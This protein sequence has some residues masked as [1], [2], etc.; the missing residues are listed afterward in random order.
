[1]ACTPPSASEETPQ[2]STE[3]QRRAGLSDQGPQPEQSPAQ[4][5]AA[6]KTEETAPTPVEVSPV[7]RGV[8]SS[9]LR[10][11]SILEPKERASVRSL[12]SGVVSEL[13]VEEGDHVTSGELIAKISRPGAGSMLRQAAS[14]YYK[15]KRDAQRIEGLVKRGLAPREELSQAKFQR[16]QSA[17]ELSRLRAESKNERITSPISG[18]VVSRALY[19]GETVSPGQQIVEVM[20]LSEVYAPL[21]LSDRWAHKIRRGLSAVMFDREGRPLTEGA[22]VARVSPVIDAETG[23][24]K[25]WVSPQPPPKKRRKRG[26][27]RRRSSKR[28]KA[29]GSS[30]AL[31]ERSALLRPG[32]F[33]TVEMTVDRHEDALILPRDAVMYRDGVPFVAVVKE[34]RARLTQVKIGF[35]EDDLIELLEP[36]R[37]G[38]LVVS[39]GQRGLE[40]GELVLITQASKGRRDRSEDSAQRAADKLKR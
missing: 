2:A 28:A 39:F 24:F 32:L 19:R 37:E 1:M 6:S 35:T 8:I 34:G 12:I 31:D 33:V 16:D 30:N 7:S 18:V 22:Q 38:D 29:Q 40:D 25:V 26:R 21:N 36:L 15:A 4:E 14:T 9:K 3:R 13:K 27:R 17:L 11:V 23:T 5:A 10:A 20:D